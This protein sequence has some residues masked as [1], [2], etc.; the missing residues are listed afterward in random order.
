MTKYC[1]RNYYNEFIS[2]R[3]KE[4]A[5]NLHI[6]CRY[7]SAS[8]FAYGLYR[9]NLCKLFFEA[10]KINKKITFD[11]SAFFYLKPSFYTPYP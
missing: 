2:Q 1:A 8:E 3:R 11:G 5:M 4:V 10:W 6:L 9:T 7:L